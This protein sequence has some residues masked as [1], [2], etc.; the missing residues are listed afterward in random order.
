MKADVAHGVPLTL[1]RWMAVVPL[2]LESN[3]KAGDGSAVSK[4][5]MQSESRKNHAG[6][7]A[8]RLPSQLREPL[9]C[10]LLSLSASLIEFCIAML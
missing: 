4:T 3:A 10:L 5:T 8:C 9:A 1:E 7:T 6:V 2:V